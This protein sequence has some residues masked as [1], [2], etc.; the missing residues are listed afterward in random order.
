MKS[1]SVRTERR[2]VGYGPAYEADIRQVVLLSGNRDFCILK[3]GCWDSYSRTYKNSL[4]ADSIYE[5][6]KIPT[7]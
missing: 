4:I 3:L 6:V 1:I 2:L 7:I 5:N